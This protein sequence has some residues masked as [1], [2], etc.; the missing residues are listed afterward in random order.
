[1]KPILCNYYITYRCNAHCA[2]CDIWQNDRYRKVSDCTLDDV[3]QNLPQLKSIGI[4][5]IDFTGGEP[6]LHSQLPA[7]LKLAKKFGFVTSVT[8]NCLL[9]PQRAGEIKGLVDLLHFSL[10]SLDENEND[11]LRGKNSFARVLESIAIAKKIGERPDLLFTATATNFKAIAELSRWAKKQ[12]LLLIVNPIFTYRDQIPL[13][14]DAI[15]YLD[16]YRNEPFVYINRA[17][18]RLIREKGN[19]RDSPRCRAVSST[20]VISPENELLLPCFHQARFAIPMQPNLTQIINSSRV[21]SIQK[22]QG[23]F[24]YCEGCT[25]NCYFDPSFLY[26]A[27]RFFWLT[28]ISKLKYGLDKYG[29]RG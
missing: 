2:Y 11:R 8:T 29:R 10:D 16:G 19:K 22:K 3:I 24:P 26:Q 18:H 27:D 12:R 14:I 4:K 20:I 7:M 21:K 13:S 23:T 25:V 28:M 1:M 9:Y 5:F 17:L 6:L 15:D